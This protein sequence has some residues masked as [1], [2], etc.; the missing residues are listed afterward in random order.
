MLLA[1]VEPGD[2]LAIM[3]NGSNDAL[4]FHL[5][6]EVGRSEPAIDGL[7]GKETGAGVEVP[8]RSIAFRRM[9]RNR[10]QTERA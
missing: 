8:A 7:G 5:P 2:G 4:T 9:R 1:G 6:P 3:I 10:E